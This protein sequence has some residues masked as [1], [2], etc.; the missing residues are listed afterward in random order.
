MMVKRV[1]FQIGKIQNGRQFVKAHYNMRFSIVWNDDLII[2][3]NC[4]EEAIKLKKDAIPYCIFA[5][6]EVAEGFGVDLYADVSTRIRHR[7]H[8]S[9]T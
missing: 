8:I 7:V 6:F 5:S 3:V 1:L 2:K 9:N 4:R